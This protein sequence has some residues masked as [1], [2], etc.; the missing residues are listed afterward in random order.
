MAASS[1]ITGEEM[2]ERVARTTELKR[3]VDPDD[4]TKPASTWGSIA[5]GTSLGSSSPLTAGAMIV[6]SRT[7]PRRHSTAPF[8]IPVSESSHV[9]IDDPAEGVRRFTLNRPEKRNAM[10]N[11]LRRELDGLRA[12]DEMRP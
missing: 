2:S 12:A 3:H 5:P 6:W 1:G 7:P 8:R 9:T 11:R 10:D 4:I